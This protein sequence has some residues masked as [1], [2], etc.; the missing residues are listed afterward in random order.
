MPLSR[1][2]AKAKRLTSHVGTESTRPPTKAAR[3]KQSKPPTGE[4]VEKWVKTEPRAFACGHLLLRNPDHSRTQRDLEL[5]S[6]QQ[7]QSPPE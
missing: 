1:R 4:V 6:V 2:D 7:E 3:E 5:Q